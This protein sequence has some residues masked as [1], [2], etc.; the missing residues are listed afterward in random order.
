MVV[1]LPLDIEKLGVKWYY[2]VGEE[3]MMISGT[4]ITDP[5]QT[6][7]ILIR[8]QI[9]LSDITDPDQTAQ[10]LIRQQIS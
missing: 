7:Q 3:L 6:S 1:K 4:Y 9:S 5:E 8:Q 2:L 10:I